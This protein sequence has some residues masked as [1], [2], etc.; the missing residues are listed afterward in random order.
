MLPARAGLALTI[1]I[2]VNP[3]A[4]YAQ[5]AAAPVT[6]K[7][8]V[9]QRTQIEEYLKVAEVVSMEELKVGVTRPKR[10]MLAPGGPIEAIAWKVVPPGRPHGYWE[11]YKSE[12]AA[13]EIDKYLGLN[14][15]PPTVERKVKG[16]TGAAVMWCTNTKSFKDHGGVPSAPPQHFA[17][18]NRQLAKAKMFDNLIGNL[19]PNLGNW[20]V[21]PSWNL[22][23]ID[24]TRAFTTDK[25]MVHKKMDRIDGE[26]WDKMQ[27]LTIEN[28][29]TVLS[30]WVGKGEIKAVLQRRDAMAADYA[31]LMAANPSFVL[32]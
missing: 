6:A 29:T 13:Y 2:A 9:D 24:H 28:L 11:S 22:I 23:L 19:D 27:A 14:M 32:R 10:A 30:P 18:W 26:L 12:I 4:A 3:V 31:K 15:V 21:D 7:I 8:W 1:A 25:N 20:L 16:T 5:A 17:S